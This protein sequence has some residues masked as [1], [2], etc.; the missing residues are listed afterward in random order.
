MTEKQF[1]D[2][3]NLYLDHEI[4]GND[5]RELK[6]A[7]RH[8]VLL[9]RKFERACEIHQAARKALLSQAGGHVPGEGTGTGARSSPAART[10]SSTGSG[11]TRPRGG[12]PVAAGPSSGKQKQSQAHRNASVVSLAE[13]QLNKGAASEVD[14]N[15]I[16]LESHGSSKPAVG[17]TFFHFLILR[18]V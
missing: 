10:A 4:G 5:L 8:N 1:D 13:R 11:L 14:L 3:T 17:G 15:R 9:R 6:D 16:S 7:I 18:W 12:R 2:L